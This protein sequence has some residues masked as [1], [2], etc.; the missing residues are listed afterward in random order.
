MLSFV[1]II[2]LTNCLIYTYNAFIRLY[3]HIYTY[4]PCNTQLPIHSYPHTYLFFRYKLSITTYEINIRHIW[5]EHTH[6]YTYTQISIPEQPIISSPTYF[7]IPTTLKI[8]P[9]THSSNTHIS[10]NIYT[11]IIQIHNHNHTLKI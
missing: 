4:L 8:Q 11:H 9:Y 3:L 6:T 1:Y 2:F 10:N 7:P 5:N